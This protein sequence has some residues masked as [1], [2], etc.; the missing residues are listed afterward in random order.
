[1]QNTNLF[2]WYAQMRKNNPVYF[3]KSWGCWNVF[4]Y[5]LSLQ[6]LRN[7]QTFS[8]SVG[9]QMFSSSVGENA[10]GG[11]LG[12]SL[13]LMD[14]PKHTLFRSLVNKSFSARAVQALEPRIEQIA[15]SLLSNLE[16]EF[17]FVESFAVPL[18][19]MV[20]AELLGVSPEDRALFKDLTDSIVGTG[21]SEDFES[22]QK[23]L[24]QYF[25]NVIEQRRKQPKRD[26]ISELLASQVE[27]R[28][29]SQ[30]E[31]LGFVILLLIAG[32]ETT[33]NLLGNAV[34]ALFENRESLRKLRSNMDELLPLTI[35]EVL[36]YYSPV[37][38]LP[39]RFAKVD[40]TL[41][42]QKISAGEQIAVWIG[43]A[44]RDEAK[45]AQADKFVIERKPNEHIAFG[46][47]PHMCLGAPLARLEAKVALRAFLT[48]FREV[49]VLQDK[50]QK[51]Q[52]GI[53]YG[54]KR[55]PVEVKRA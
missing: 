12:G 42:G 43:S 27:G 8:S 48:S 52:G 35:E 2:D 53:I 10:E 51:I 6:V 54:F 46:A 29:L 44:N 20:I 7:P 38:L 21:G 14:P 40:T 45:F 47:G 49:E 5:E 23:K 4:T 15:N 28:T 41:G 55:L 18:P 26:L 36:R 11:Y 16:G 9:E 13:I 50:A 32:N 37:Q 24:A 17:D 3:D 33:T 30:A 19:V 25:L 31:L 1:M 39:H 22:A 34:Y